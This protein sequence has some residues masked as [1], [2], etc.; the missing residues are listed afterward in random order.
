MGAPGAGRRG[1]GNTAGSSGAAESGG[2]NLCA[3]KGAFVV[4]GTAVRLMLTLA[5]GSMLSQGTAR[6]ERANVLLGRFSN[7]N[8]THSPIYTSVH[9]LD[10][11]ED[12]LR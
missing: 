10:S 5:H 7:P 6:G 2:H 9:E 12:C 4:V 3:S 8:S 1:L 11:E